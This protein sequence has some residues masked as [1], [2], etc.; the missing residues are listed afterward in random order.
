[1]RERVPLLSQPAPSCFSPALRRAF[2]WALVL[3]A[4]DDIRDIVDHRPGARPVL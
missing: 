2:R 3:F 1:M 4:S